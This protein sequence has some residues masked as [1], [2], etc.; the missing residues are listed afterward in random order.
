MRPLK[1]IQPN[2][3]LASEHVSSQ[4][5]GLAELFADETP[6]YFHGHHVN[7]ELEN[8]IKD[9]R[10]RIELRRM[11]AQYEAGL[12][13]PPV[14]Y[15]NKVIDDP[16]YNNER[17]E[18]EDNIRGFLKEDYKRNDFHFKVKT[19]HKFPFHF[20]L[21]IKIPVFSFVAAQKNPIIYETNNEEENDDEDMPKTSFREMSREYNIPTIHLNNKFHERH[22]EPHYYAEESNDI[23]VEPIKFKGFHHHNSETNDISPEA[24]VYTEGGLVF[25]P[26]SNDQAEASRECWHLFYVYFLVL[27]VKIVFMFP[28]VV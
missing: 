2:E 3:P 8:R 17:P 26:E 7:Q 14:Y 19:K 21:T 28:C 12:L 16:E 24:G 15:S 9:L 25:V 10:N 13:K 20:F 1:T 11:L 4:P 27:F 18:P 22:H 6:Q 23:P 5:S